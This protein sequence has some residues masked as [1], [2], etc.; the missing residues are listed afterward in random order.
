MSSWAGQSAGPIGVAE[1]TVVVCPPA[2]ET[3]AVD[4]RRATRGSPGV[5][6]ALGVAGLG[7]GWSPRCDGFA[8]VLGA[9]GLAAGGLHRSAILP[10]PGTAV[11][12]LLGAGA[13]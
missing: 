9:P 12:A 6:D 1:V 7:A 5:G 4:P 11:E 8:D 3:L 10:E 13:R 2:T